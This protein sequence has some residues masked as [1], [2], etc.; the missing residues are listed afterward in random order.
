MQW[1]V[2]C[3]KLVQPSRTYNWKWLAL[4]IVSFVAIPIVLVLLAALPPLGALLYLLLCLFFILGLIGFV[5]SL[6]KY[7]FFPAVVCPICKT[8]NILK[9]RP[10]EGDAE[11]EAYLKQKKKFRA[12]LSGYTA[13]LWFG[14][15]GLFLPFL[16]P[17]AVI[18]SI[19]TM[20]EEEED[21][22]KNKRM[23]PLVLGIIGSIEL[24]ILIVWLSISAFAADSWIEAQAQAAKKGIWSE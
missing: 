8:E 18:K 10:P 24:I 2:Y 17:V 23:I 20:K 4:I 9:E 19:K 1:C 12:P 5:G 6:I 14:T 13:R 11:H 21:I 16:A 3:E 15:A 7:I 22:S